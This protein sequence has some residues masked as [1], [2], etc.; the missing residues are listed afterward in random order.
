[1]NPR[2]M[3]WRNLR[4][5]GALL[6]LGFFVNF[7]LIISLTVARERVRLFRCPLWVDFPDISGDH[8]ANLE[9]KRLS[10]FASEAPDCRK[11]D[12][13]GYLF[14]LLVVR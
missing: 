2:H 1:M 12:S 6:R 7:G 14:S 10:L 5:P 13:M 3:I 11:V 8:A 4:G 9:P